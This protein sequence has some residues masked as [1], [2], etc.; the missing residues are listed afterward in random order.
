LLA[1]ERTLTNN[2]ELLTSLPFQRGVKTRIF[3]KQ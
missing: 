1:R 3:L 2:S